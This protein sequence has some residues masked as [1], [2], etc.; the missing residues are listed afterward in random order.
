MTKPGTA[1][2]AVVT[3][4][5]G[6][7][8][9]KFS[10]MWINLRSSGQISYPVLSRSPW[11]TLSLSEWGEL[12]KL[13]S[14][15]R[16]FLWKWSVLGVCLCKYITLECVLWAYGHRRHHLGASS[17]PPSLCMFIFIHL[18]FLSLSM[19]YNISVLGHFELFELE[20]HF[21]RFT[22]NCAQLPPIPLLLAA[23]IAKT[24]WRL[25]QRCW[26]SWLTGVFLPNIL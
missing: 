22:P 13:H 6:F 8:S 23:P 1:F 24:P 2:K 14:H 5:W 25:D 19:G 12:W 11:R 7:H 4:N 18:S 21:R 16:A 20:H 10:G 15:V 17:G 9:T 3:Y 26:S